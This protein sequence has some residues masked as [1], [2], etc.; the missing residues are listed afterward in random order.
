MKTPIFFI[1]FL[2]VFCK[3]TA[4]TCTQFT[5]MKPG[6]VI[7]MTHYDKKGKMS[8]RT[9]NKVNEVSS[10]PSGTTADITTTG[11]DED[12]EEVFK[13]DVTAK[14]SDDKIYISMQNVIPAAQ[15][16]SF[17]D[18]EVKV[19][20]TMLEYPTSMKTEGPLSD[21]LYTAELY[22]GDTKIMTFKYEIT[23]RQIVGKETITSPAGTWDCFKITYTA[24][25]K[26]LLSSTVEITEWYYPGI[27]IIKSESTKNGKSMGYSI[28]TKIK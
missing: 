14:C 5:N 4:Q 7:E 17:D 11:F 18:M 6:S 28:L 21:A 10:E 16:E 25:F 22:S 9:V 26:A 3:V 27:G 19:T 12:N 1:L 24:K 23:E 20:E 2:S 13:L 15:L 8:T